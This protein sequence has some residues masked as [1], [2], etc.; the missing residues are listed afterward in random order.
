MQNEQF[1]DGSMTALDMQS[2]DTG[3]GLERV[4]ALLQGSH[5]NYDTDLFRALTQSCINWCHHWCNRWGLL[6][7][8]WGKAS[9]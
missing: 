1:A 4:A 2:I 6:I 9:A 5:D 7:L 8:N 3:M